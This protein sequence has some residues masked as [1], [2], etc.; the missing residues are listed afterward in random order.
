MTT[1]GGHLLALFLDRPIKP[2]R[3]LRTTILAIHDAGGLAIPAHPLVP[4][5][6]CAQGWVLRRLLDDPDP[7]AHPDALET[8]NPTSLGKP[9]HRRVVRFADDHGLAHVGNSD[10]HALAAIG[11]GWTTFPGRD[12]T[13]LRRAIET[14]GDRARRVLPRDGRSARHVRPPAAQARPRRAR[15][16]RRPGPARRHRARP[17]LSRRPPPAA[18]LR[19]GPRRAASG[20]EDRPGLP[21]HLPGARRRR[22][23]RP[24]PL[25]EPSPARPRRPDHHR[26]P[27][28][29]ARLGGRHPAHRGRLQRP[30]QRLDRDADVLAALHQPGARPARARALRRP[31]LPRAVRA[32][33][34]ALPA[35]RVTQRQRRHVP[36]LRRLLAVVRGRQPGHEGPRGAAPRP[37]RGQRRGAPLHRPL[38]PRRL[39]G[40]PQRR[41]HP[42]LRRCGPA[43]A[44]AGRHAQ[45]PVRRSPRTAQGPARPAQG[46]PHPAPDRVR[47]PV[48]GGR[49]GAAGARGAPL[50]R[51]ARA[52]GRRV[53]RPRD[54]RRE[55]AA[56][57]DRRRLR[58]A[59]D[60]RRVVRDRAARGDGRRRPDRR[61]GHPRLQGRRPARS[62]GPARPA[63]RAQGAG[64][65]H[66]PAAR[67]PRAAR[68]DERRRPR[69]SRAVQLAAGDGQGRR[70]LRLRR[71]AASPRPAS[72][73]RTSARRCLRR[74]RSGP[75]RPHPRTTPRP[76][77]CRPASASTP[78]PSRRPPGRSPSGRAAGSPA[79]A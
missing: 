66:R 24:A 32:V 26:Q 17:R 38:L 23:A 28:P 75:G 11:Q 59:G 68:L 50:R 13:D 76:R 34:V 69:A 60:R 47:E 67:R 12:A 56:V 61:L 64:D 19:G 71:S 73:P 31:P 79:S 55:G 21:V 35:A 39:Q 3:S 44:L 27:R 14:A 25:R 16:G 1:L 46:A 18:A 65:G 29:A 22:P 63:A 62:R 15:R 7:A 4:Y 77:V 78:T 51:D 72:C 10:A 20:D 45:R 5:P 57:P 36:R 9:W 74:R 58:V 70:L 30:A 49:L 43:R 33:A 2:Y 37:D 41:R 6:L 42:A 8:F 54:R 40:H 52:P 53:P 48:A